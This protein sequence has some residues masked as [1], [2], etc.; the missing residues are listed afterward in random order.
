MH[1][2]FSLQPAG[3]LN[4]RVT[5][6]TKRSR[7]ASPSVTRN[8]TREEE[9]R[10]CSDSE[11]F[12]KQGD[13]SRNPENKLP[14]EK[15]VKGNICLKMSS[16]NDKTSTAMSGARSHESVDEGSDWFSSTSGSMISSPMGRISPGK[17]GRMTPL[18]AGRE[19]LLKEAISQRVWEHMPQSDAE[20]GQGNRSPPQ[21]MSNDA[22]SSNAGGN[23]LSGSATD[24]S[25]TVTRDQHR[26]SQFV[27][28]KTSIEHTDG[29]LL[30]S[31]GSENVTHTSSDI[32]IKRPKDYFRQ[33]ED[34]IDRLSHGPVSSD[35]SRSSSRSR[36]RSHESNRILGEGPHKSS[37][38]LE[39]DSLRS[40]SYSPS[41]SSYGRSVPFTYDSTD[42]FSHRLSS[43]SPQRR[44][45][46][47]NRNKEVPNLGRRA[48]SAGS[49][50]S[51]QRE[52]SAQYQSL[53]DQ[54]LKQESPEDK[55]D[56][57]HISDYGG[58]SRQQML[59]I[60]HF[61]SGA[62]LKDLTLSLKPG[63]KVDVMILFE[64]LRKA[65]EAVDSN[66]PKDDFRS[67][68][69]Q[70]QDSA[71]TELKTVN[72]ES[73]VEPSVSGLR[74]NQCLEKQT[75]EKGS[76]SE[77][78][79]E[80]QLSR[81]HS[82]GRDIRDVERERSPSA[83]IGLSRRH[84]S[85]SPRR[86]PVAREPVRENL[87][88]GLDGVARRESLETVSREGREQLEGGC[89]RVPRREAWERRRQKNL[90]N[91]PLDA[92]RMDSLV[93]AKFVEVLCQEIEELKHKVEV[94]DQP[95]QMAS[96]TSSGQALPNRYGRRNDYGDI[97]RIEN[98]FQLETDIRDENGRMLFETSRSRSA[99]PH[100]SQKNSKCY[101]VESNPYQY[102][103]R[104][105]RS[106][107]M[108]SHEALRN[109]LD[110]PRSRSLSPNLERQSMEYIQA[111]G[112][113][114]RSE[115]FRNT[116]LPPER[117]GPRVI[118][119]GS[120]RRYNPD[121]RSSRHVSSLSVS[122]STPDLSKQQQQQHY[123]ISL[124]YSSPVRSVSQEIWGNKLTGVESLTP[125]GQDRWKQLIS[126]RNLTDEDI[127][128]LKQAL[129]GS[130]VENDILQ[131][132]LN[133]AKAEVSEKLSQTNGILDDCRKHLA[134]SQAEN[135]ELRSNLERERQQRQ[136][137]E[138]RVKELE[139]SLYQSKS[140]VSRMD[141]ELNRT[142]DELNRT[143]RDEPRL[144]EMRKENRLLQGD[145]SQ[146]E[147]INSSLK[148]VCVKHQTLKGQ[149]VA[150]PV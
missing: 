135:M 147:N 84:P 87:S 69:L 142:R 61:L 24:S 136:D 67:R 103:E 15:P 138:V 76:A 53:Q 38:Y 65:R 8:S 79:E 54:D 29:R 74:L 77:T 119:G 16:K 140:D 127:I 44:D 88:F 86:L 124:G 78:L 52:A 62:D 95:R 41:R 134:K 137:L 73:G 32:K 48:E 11:L 3:G 94:M 25:E 31:K 98:P 71:E 60:Q 148:Q 118:S 85:M 96:S 66:M 141:E 47:L 6:Q 145:L 82:P 91:I 114:M 133:N 112:S 70:Q 110:Q 144:E 123:P 2:L 56:A 149:S 30:G 128:E 126:N 21:R 19:Q 72:S 120:P 20:E 108:D 146:V 109:G 13:T 97:D 35:S 1:T 83:V 37:I 49:T 50:Q 68:R 36:S 22:H 131:A 45:V 57:G 89:S 132:K 130:I 59:E 10:N 100:Y 104:L 92:S 55:S 17:D 111:T 14:C 121:K 115:D 5:S 117:C 107:H 93:Q 51:R 143:I 18:D 34:T 42:G 4:L 58:D 105:G 101:R 27:D 43:P 26:D 129:A 9:E 46:D 90:D 28:N 80:C 113:R 64:A 116:S 122:S 63:Q 139:E 12:S 40:V 102:Q 81:I 150:Q 23:I 7:S 39:R 106:L 125:L 75:I 99:S 33:W